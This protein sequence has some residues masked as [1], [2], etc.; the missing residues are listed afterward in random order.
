M[1]RVKWAYSRLMMP[2]VRVMSPSM[3]RW[4]KCV[5]RVVVLW[6]SRGRSVSRRRSLRVWAMSVGM[7]SLCLRYSLVIT[8]VIRLRW[9]HSNLPGRVLLRRRRKGR[10][11]RE[12]SQKRMLR[13]GWRMLSKLCCVCARREGRM[14]IIVVTWSTQLFWASGQPSADNTVSMR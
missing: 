5:I 9:I 8:E 1:K 6:I 11:R 14:C 2:K 3:K 10:I 4:V 13:S 7:E 12:G